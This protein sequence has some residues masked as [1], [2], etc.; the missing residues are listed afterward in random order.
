MAEHPILDPDNIDLSMFTAFGFKKLNE[1]G[2]FVCH[3]EYR[4]H[5]DDFFLKTEKLIGLQTI[6]D[7]A[8]VFRKYKQEPYS[9]EYAIQSFGSTASKPKF[10]QFLTEA[11]K[12]DVHVI[13]G[14]LNNSDQSTIK[15]S[16]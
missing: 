10:M 8:F 13:E 9:L 4:P 6:T 5:L 15:F 16:I 7:S 2:K 12:W 14:V 11:Q 1:E 3:G